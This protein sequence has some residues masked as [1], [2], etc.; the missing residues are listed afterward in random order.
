M[1]LFASYRMQSFCASP[2]QVGDLAGNVNRSLTRFVISLCQGRRLVTGGGG[3]GIVGNARD[4]QSDDKR[5]VRTLQAQVQA[6]QVK[7]QSVEADITLQAQVQ[8]L[9]VSSI[10]AEN[11]EHGG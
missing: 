4:T 1:C 2:S 6:L 8:A 3:R 9:L 10:E 7:I 5:D 11:S